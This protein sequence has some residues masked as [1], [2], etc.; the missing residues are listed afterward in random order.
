M[1]SLSVFQP[2]EDFL[3]DLVTEVG[4]LEY[5]T[6]DSLTETFNTV[7]AE[8]IGV[9]NLTVEITSLEATNIAFLVSYSDELMESIALDADLGLPA[10]GLG[11]DTEGS[12]DF[13]LSYEANLGF[14]VSLEYGF[15]L[16]L[17][18]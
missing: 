3:N 7:L 11:I 5:V 2:I 4:N 1:G 13:A 6:A 8:D 12:L 17:T 16:D 15:Y 10:L 14:G 18:P 9:D